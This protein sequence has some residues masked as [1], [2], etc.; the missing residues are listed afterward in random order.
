MRD[1]YHGESLTN[2]NQG[3][4]K[5]EGFLHITSTTKDFYLRQAFINAC[6]LTQ[7]PR[8]WEISLIALRDLRLQTITENQ[9]SP[10]WYFKTCSSQRA[11]WSVGWGHDLPL[12]TLT[13]WTIQ[14]CCYRYRITLFVITFYAGREFDS[15]EMW[16]LTP[17]IVQVCM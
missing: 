9:W 16:L 13:L 8:R 6:G 15:L 2:K 14:T 4:T 1:S 5:A 11:L 17:V 3:E 7:P 10:A 12:E